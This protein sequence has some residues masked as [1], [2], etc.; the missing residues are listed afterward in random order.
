M[1]PQALPSESQG[2]RRAAAIWCWA[3]L[4]FL[5]LPVL[6]I[7]VMSFARGPFLSFPPSGF[8]LRWYGEYVF[9]A[10]WMSATEISLQVALAAGLLATLLGTLAAFGLAR[11]DMPVL[12]AARAFIAAPLVVP[13]IVSAV[14][15]YFFFARLGLT[16]TRAGLILADTVLAVP[17][18]SINV[19]TALQGLD[20]NLEQAALGLGA[21]PWRVFRHVTWPLLRPAIGAGFLLAFLL[22]FD[23]LVVALFLSGVETTTLP[24]RLWNSLRDELDP[25]VAAASTLLIAVCIVI[26][27]VIEIFRGR[28]V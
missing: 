26:V 23:E 6:T 4:L 9:S 27:A 15:F 3:M 13:G 8:S 20:R 17:L 12:R 19:G 14:A 21:S 22:S 1:K 28:A 7:A 25:T 5:N 16:G 2:L 10:R 18:V 11:G 24:V